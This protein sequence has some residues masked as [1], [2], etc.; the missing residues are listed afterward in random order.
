MKKYTFMF[1]NVHR[2]YAI[3]GKG[4]ECQRG[5]IRTLPKMAKLMKMEGMFFGGS[6][7]CLFKTFC[8]TL[9][10]VNSGQNSNLIL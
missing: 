5:T 8:K 6:R 3:Y 9:H 2:E 7:K 4:D 1:L 10:S